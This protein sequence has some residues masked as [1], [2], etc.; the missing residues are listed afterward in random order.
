MMKNRNE[1]P[2]Q[3]RERRRAQS[4]ELMAALRRKRGLRTWDQF[5]ASLPRSDEGKPW[6]AEGISRATWFRR[7]ANAGLTGLGRSADR[8]AWSAKKPPKVRKG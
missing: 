7:R 5:V 6:E 2:Q 3:R 4:R 1:T 8:P